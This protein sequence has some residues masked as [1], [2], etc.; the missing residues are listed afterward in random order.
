MYLRDSPVLCTRVPREQTCTVGVS[1]GG[2]WRRA[3]LSRE[4]GNRVLLPESFVWLRLVARFAPSASRPVERN[5]FPIPNNGPV[6]QENS[7]HFR[8][9]LGRRQEDKSPGFCYDSGGLLSPILLQRRVSP[10]VKAVQT[11]PAGIARTHSRPLSASTWQ[12]RMPSARR[13]SSRC[14][15]STQ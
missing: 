12:S 8:S 7:T 10:V 14:R 6:G 15:E 4:A 1:C 2:S 11:R 9:P 3:R 13:S 5:L